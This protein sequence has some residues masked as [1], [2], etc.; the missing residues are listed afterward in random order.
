MEGANWKISWGMERTING[1]TAQA[2]TPEYFTGVCVCVCVC[3]CV[4][5]GGGV[6]GADRE[7]IDN[8]C[9]VLKLVS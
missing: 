8:L 9:L 7:V 2:I 3:V 4:W 5:E 1:V 6:E